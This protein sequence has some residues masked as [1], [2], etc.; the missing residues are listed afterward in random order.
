MPR[1]MSL[2]EMSNEEVETVRKLA[3]SR[4]LPARTVERAGIIWLA[5][6]GERVSAIAEQLRLNRITVRRWIAR[7]NQGGVASLA[8][9]PRMGRP[10]TYTREQVGEVIATALTDPRQIACD[11]PLPF[12]AWTLERLATYLK[13]H[14]DIPIS[15]SRV[16]ALLRK[17]GLRWRFQERWFG[18]LVSEQARVELDPEFAQ[19]RGPSSTSTLS[20]H[21]GA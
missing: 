2:R 15:P 9:D 6:R 3:H 14:R 11:P 18:N 7:F 13:E 12:G 20:P 17:E 16:G 21:K 10:P 19:K 4:T 5:S 1:L 8:D